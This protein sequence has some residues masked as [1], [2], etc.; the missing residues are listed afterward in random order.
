M[1]VNR[2]LLYWSRTIHIYF[3]IALLLLLAFFAITGITLNHASE[4]AAEPVV[5]ARTVETLPELP[6]DEAGMIADSPELAQFLRREFGLRRDLATLEVSPDGLLVDYRAP[7]RSAFVEIDVFN[8]RAAFELT[9]FGVIALLND[10]H[11][12]R[13]TDVI[14]KWLVDA[15]GVLIV[16]FSL[17]GFVLLLPSQSRL[18]R[19]T[20]VTL[21]GLG[22]LAAAY[23]LA[24]R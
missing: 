9:D 14:W 15:S 18:K 13:D 22:L 20:L 4:L 16:V 8:G 17:A 10:L 12:A 3:S 6:L 21:L 7:G 19:V 2:S 5:M 23:W 24:I 11:K 1:S